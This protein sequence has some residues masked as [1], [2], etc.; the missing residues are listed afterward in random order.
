MSKKFKT[1]CIVPNCNSGNSVKFNRFPKDTKQCQRWVQAVKNP[2]LETLTLQEV[3]TYRVC[4]LHFTKDSFFITAQRPRLKWDAVPVL[5]LPSSSDKTSKELKI[6]LQSDEVGKNKN[7]IL[8]AKPKIIED[9]SLSYD[10]KNNLLPEDVVPAE[11]N[12]WEDCLFKEISPVEN[13]LSFA[14]K[15]FRRAEKGKEI[16]IA[17][18][19]RANLYKSF[20]SKSLEN[21]KLKSIKKVP[22]KENREILKTYCIVPNCKSGR[23][24]TKH[25]FPKDEYIGEKWVKAIK[26]PFLKGISYEEIRKRRLFVCYLHFPDDSW[27]KN[28]NVRPR[29]KPDAVP[30]LGLPEKWIKKEKLIP[31]KPI[32]L[33]KNEE[34]VPNVEMD[35]Y[36]MTPM[37]SYNS[38]PKICD[39]SMKNENIRESSFKV[40]TSEDFDM[41]IKYRSINN[42]SGFPFETKYS[43]ETGV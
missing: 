15:E 5:R 41:N 8:K 36:F 14:S 38:M 43:K 37:L 32:D 16:T 12:F 17:F 24:I 21:R 18:K 10:E 27:T 19:I 9:Y 2:F 28:A 3:Q 7:F 22:S 26:S 34:E 33:P 25:A 35:V 40:K 29:L 1:R 13:I 31:R 30:E 4:H 42:V 39:L 6:D 20:N 23:H 11:N